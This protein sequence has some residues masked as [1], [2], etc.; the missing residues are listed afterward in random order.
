[1]KLYS[2][3]AQIHHIF[4]YNLSQNCLWER[5]IWNTPLWEDNMKYSSPRGQY[6]ILLSQRTIWKTPLPEDNM[7]NSPRGQYEILLCKNQSNN[8][9]IIY[10]AEGNQLGVYR[11]P[12]CGQRPPGLHRSKKKTQI[13][14]WNSSNVILVFTKIKVAYIN[15]VNSPTKI[16]NEHLAAIT[17]L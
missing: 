10:V 1:M 16:N 9:E 15:P 6:E 14:V 8:P 12:R 13:A 11:A 2:S 7:K 3:P 5:R 17:V 4:S